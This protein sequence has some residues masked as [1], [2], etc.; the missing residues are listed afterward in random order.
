MEDQEVAVVEVEVADHREVVGAH[1]DRGVGVRPH[2]AGVGHVDRVPGGAGG[3][4]AMEDL[5]V[6]VRDVGV[7]H[8]RQAVGADR[9]RRVGSDVRGAGVDGRH[10]VPRRARDVAAVEDLQVEVRHVL[11]AHDRQA[12]RADR[13]GG[14]RADASGA[15]DGGGLVPGRARFVPAVKDLQI[16]AQ[17]AAR[18]VPVAHHRKPVDSDRDGRV[19]AHD[20]G[21]VQRDDERRA[22]HLGREGARARARPGAVGL[23]PAL[24]GLALEREERVGRRGRV[25][26]AV[27]VGLGVVAG[28]RGGLLVVAGVRLLLRVEE[29]HGQGLHVLRPEVVHA[30]ADVPARRGRE[31]R[32][33]H[34][35]QAEERDATPGA[36]DVP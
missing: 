20:A 4:A 31:H 9:Q 6:A 34:Q 19:V 11:V 32:H 14:V 5:E 21:R 22:A 28:V 25:V 29:L 24:A 26:A 16:G 33:E 10:L 36:H 23:E 2:G 7:A 18:R 35:S 15:V 27:G 12:V 8:H 3:V 30:R 1:G 13:E 17:V